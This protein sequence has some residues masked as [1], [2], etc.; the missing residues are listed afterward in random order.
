[1]QLVFIYKFVVKSIID[2]EI[3]KCE[4]KYDIVLLQRFL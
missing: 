1:M 4:N 2:N 3:W